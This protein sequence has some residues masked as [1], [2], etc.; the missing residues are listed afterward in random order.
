[1]TVLLVSELAERSG[2]PA[3]APRFYEEQGLLRADHS[4][5]GYRLFAE[6]TV[7]RLAFISAAELLGPDLGEIDGLVAVW[8]QGSCAQVRAD[9][10]ETR[11]DQARTRSTELAAFTGRLEQARAH[12]AGPSPTGPA[13]PRARCCTPAAR[14][15]CRR[16][17]PK[18]PRAVRSP[19]VRPRGGVHPGRWPHPCGGRAV[20][21]PVRRSRCGRTGSPGRGRTEVLRLLRLRPAPG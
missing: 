3:S 20:P 18:R 17:W 12:L 2:F 5:S 19:D 14:L 1:M 16:R 4:S 21:A 6:D 9:L 11:T 10:Q 13:I 15:R 7:D 8:D